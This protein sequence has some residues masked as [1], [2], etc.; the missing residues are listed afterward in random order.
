MPLLPEPE[1]AA[2][3]AMDALRIA[4]ST[5]STRTLREITAVGHEL[6]SFQNLPPVKVLLDRLVDV[7]V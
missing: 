2:T 1:R 7:A 5:G 6:N 3:V 4:R